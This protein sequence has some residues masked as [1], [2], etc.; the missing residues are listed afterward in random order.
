MKT[1]LSPNQ[2]AACNAYFHRVRAWIT[3]VLAVLQNACTPSCTRVNPPSGKILTFDTTSTVASNHDV[4]GG[5]ILPNPALCGAPG[6]AFLSE[7]VSGGDLEKP[8]VPYQWANVIEGNRQTQPFAFTPKLMFAEGTI[9][10]ARQSKNDLLF[11]H[12]F[13]LDFTF[14]IKLD[15]HYEDLNQYAYWAWNNSP[16]FGNRPCACAS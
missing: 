9:V 5:R 13:G 15:P 10:G 14:E 1:S 2:S 6:V 12:P 11:A 8:L 4:P 7:F 16:L 3:I